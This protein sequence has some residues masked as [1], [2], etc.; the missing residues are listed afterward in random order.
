MMMVM[1]VMAMCWLGHGDRAYTESQE[2]YPGKV[3]KLH[4]ISPL[5]WLDFMVLSY[6]KPFLAAC[7]VGNPH[8]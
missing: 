2:Q 4:E 8:Q 7:V 1:V 3:P 6:N 5:K